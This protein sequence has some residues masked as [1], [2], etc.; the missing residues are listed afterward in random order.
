[1]KKAISILLAI[2]LLMSAFPLCALAGRYFYLDYPTVYFRGNSES[3]YDE[4]GTQVYD[5]D[6]DTA[7]LPDMLKAVMPS[8]AKGYLT[9]D[10]NDYYD[11]FELE[12]S[13]LYD[14]CQLDGNGNPKYGTGISQEHKER[15]EIRSKSNYFSN[16]VC[17][18]EAYVYYYD[19]RLDPLE[20][21]DLIAQYIDS[22]L[23][24]TGK[25]K[26]NLICKCLGGNLILSYLAKY[27]TE[28]VN[29]I[30]F[31][32]TVAFG[33]DLID[34]IYAG[35]VVVDPEAA[36]RFVN[37]D[38]IT[39][40]YPEDF[41]I[42]FEIASE[43]VDLATRTG[44]LGFTKDTISYIFYK[45]V[46][47]GLVPAM[48]RS[49]YGTWPGYWAMVTADRYESTRDFIFDEEHKSNY[50]G[51]IEKLDNYDKLVRQR[52]PE[53]L[54]NA[55]ADGVKIA[56]VSKYGSQMPPVIKSADEQGD[57]WT[58]TRYSSLG[59]KVSK[60]GTTLSPEYIEERKALGYGKYIS[61]DNQVDA[62]TCLFPD[63]TWFIK[64]AVHNDWT[65]EEN[66]ILCNVFASKTQLT[67]DTMTNYPQFLVYH[68]ETDTTSPM[69]KENC[70]NESF[71]V[72]EEKPSFLDTVRL[73][74]KWIKDVFNL[75][76]NYIKGSQK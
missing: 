70:D 30:G 22:V 33:C 63:Y 72:D 29:A 28:K 19:W 45:Q 64:G 11:A 51:L 56:I 1:M 61:P 21:A 60:T 5:F 38:F 4:N 6:F 76:V 39:E 25:D 48:I 50:S 14:R 24:A 44:I 53:I 3:I 65:D 55:E 75:L 17:D 8:L 67:V 59:A 20:T 31:G 74:F 23:Q 46:Y 15:N 47:K 36:N 34:D 49:S 27:G 32:S 68:R 42:P 26:V 9:N 69:T 66:A 2:I 16:G 12:L 10:F 73:W 58:T 40:M 18:Y 13:K 37:D 7:L 35:D 54:K 62:S 52:I 57:V 71:P 43:T 41:V